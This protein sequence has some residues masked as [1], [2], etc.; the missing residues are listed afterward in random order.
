MAI[1][2]AHGR[3]GVPLMLAT[4]VLVFH[5]PPLGAIHPAIKP[6]E[7]VAKHLSSIGSAEARS[8]VKNR[9]A[10]GAAQVTFRLPTSGRLP[11]NGTILSDG[12][13]VRIEMMF[14]A[15]DYQSERLVFDGRSV[16][17][18]QLRLRV[19]SNLA[20]FVYQYD[21]LLKEGLMGGTMTTAW[22]L[23]DLAGRQ[24]KLDYAGLRKVEG[25]QLHELR[26]RP[27]RGAWDLQIALF[28]DPQDFRHVLSQYRLVLRGRMAAAPPD[29]TSQM[30]TFYRIDERFDDFR[31]VDALILPH[32]YQLVFNRE[33]PGTGVLCEY[34]IALDRILHNQSIDADAFVIH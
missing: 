28:F 26:Y 29:S 24:P 34:R 16:D 15:L 11:G 22:P 9:V 13:R 21:V 1:G 14:A 5:D 30:D 3:R 19:R 33:G 31:P 12:G 18:G 17:V 8:A 6:E 2:S 25:K 20:D 10:S 32:A 27:R 4:L 7:L 23:L